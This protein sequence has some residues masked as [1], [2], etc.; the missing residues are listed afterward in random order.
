MSE[1]ND[2]WKQCAQWMVRCGVLDRNHRV[3]SPR[4]ELLD[5][6]QALRDGVLL[7]QLV[8]RLNRDSI[9]MNEVN[10]RPQLSQFSCTKNISL[11]LNACH[12]LFGLQTDDLCEPIEIYRASNFGKL[13]LTLSKLSHSKLALSSGVSGFPESND[14]DDDD[15]QPSY[16]NSE[17]YRRLA[18]TAESKELDGELYSE[19]SDVQRDQIYDHI[20]TKAPL[21]Q[22]EEEFVA[23]DQLEHCIKELVDTE[24]KYVN[25][26]EMIMQRFYNPLKDALRPEDHNVI[27]MNL[28]ASFVLHRVHTAFLSEI[29]VSARLWFGQATEGT[30]TN[31]PGRA[32]V[33]D[34]FVKYKRL[35]CCYSDYCSGLSGAQRKIDELC[36]EK[37]TIRQSILACQLEANANK[38]RL[39]DVLVVPMQRV[40]KYHLLL[41]EL[42]KHTPEDC[43]ER[44]SLSLGWDAMRD[45]SL[46]LNEV[47]RDCE[48]QQIIR[49]IQS[50]IDNLTEWLPKSTSLIDYG[51]PLKD[52]DIKVT[53]FAERRSDVEKK[54]K[55]RYVFAFDKVLL[56]CKPTKGNRYSYKDAL[57]LSDYELEDVLDTN[58]GFRN[59]NIREMAFYFVSDNVS[60]PTARLTEHALSYKCFERPTECDS[61]HKFLRGLFFQGYQCIICG[62]SLHKECIKSM[63]AC[64]RRDTLL[65]SPTLLEGGQKYVA[66]APYMGEG[67]PDFLSFKENDVIQLLSRCAGREGYWYGRVYEGDNAGQMGFFLPEY[68]RKQADVVKRTTWHN[69]IEE[70]RKSQ[71]GADQSNLPLARWNNVSSPPQV[72]RPTSLSSLGYV[73]LEELSH[74]PW[75][76]GELDRVR[77]E[78]L[79]KGLPMGTFLVRFSRA[80]SQYA[81]SISYFN[82][83]Y[84]V[85]HLKVEMGDNRFYLD[86]DLYFASL[87]ELVNHYEDHNLRQ[88]FRALDTTLKIPVKAIITGFA[89]ALHD[90]EATAPNMVSFRRNDLVIILSKKDSERG[91]WRGMVNGRMGYFPCSYVIEKEDF[92]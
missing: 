56:I 87:V 85:K 22:E 6:A 14:Q 31:G 71:T 15:A 73:N 90:F 17:I 25:S 60:P 7:C 63:M 24:R 89:I 62:I 76:V 57:I 69:M 13:L 83:R 55:N 23:K 29:L 88:S 75:Y 91:W 21:H 82:E 41:K 59:D 48:T 61:C 74:Y 43:E 5:F 77:A 70:K 12:N 20:V 92:G 36:T 51:R 53:L 37:S 35:F 44:T 4:A 30:S 1:T 50:S 66:I 80:R 42:L 46:Y 40:L 45:L 3:M 33:G 28:P 34:V 78:Q 58:H 81:I 86:T 16:Y 39:Q 8:N 10:L 79:I 2:F 64:G 19:A 68:V 38:F 26:L 52:G 27:F 49:D 67:G 9:D 65:R 54:Q 84:E 32:H 11:F 47:T 18:E 72:T